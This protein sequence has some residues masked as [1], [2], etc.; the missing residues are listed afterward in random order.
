MFAVQRDHAMRGMMV[1][2]VAG[3]ECS[4]KIA[5]TALLGWFA[6]TFLLPKPDL[7]RR[8]FLGKRTTRIC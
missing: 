1:L 2:L 4:A 6:T 7:Q 8:V 5:M 3:V